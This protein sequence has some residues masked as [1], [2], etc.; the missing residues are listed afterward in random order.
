MI[1]ILTSA[2]AKAK[3]LNWPLMQNNI[4]R[5]DLNAAIEFL[6]QDDP[7]LT[8]SSQVQ[9]FE[10]E[11]SEWLGTKH[12]VFVNSGSSANLLTM[13]ALKEIYG[14]G[15]V[16][17]PTLAWVSDIAS[18]L[19]CGFKPVFV[20]ID[21]HTLGMDIDQVL[22]KISS[23]TRAVFLSH[24]LGYNALNQR[25]LNELKEQSIPLIED[26]CESCGAIYQG[27]KLGTFGLMSNFSFY[28]AHH[29]STIE[30]GMIST[31][32]PDFYEILRML[33]SHGM[34]R[35]TQSAE[36]QQLYCEQ[37]PDLS[38]DFIFAFPAYNVR[39]NEINAV[40]G[41]SQLR[42]LDD[43]NKIRT[44]NLK[45]FLENLNP[46]KYFTDFATEGSCNYA[47]ALVLR[48][49]DPALCEHVMQALRQHGIEFRR[50]GS[51]GGNQLR[52]PY[53]R[54][55]VG[56]A[57]F[58]NYPHVNHIHFYGFYIG[59]YPDLEKEKILLLCSI[60]NDLN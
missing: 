29:L 59:N 1:D 53:L 4:T 46:V 20:D 6:I 49:P 51:G 54:Q 16:I 40:I 23:K 36:L 35:E 10:Q 31:D 39:N 44:E 22:Q 32:N 15:E 47:L 34:V 58:E 25:L 56:K 2:P 24:I 28:Y 8:Q 3:K 27:R 26:V 38:P 17:V 7:I 30:G 43:N 9:A 45:L 41:R 60:L 11:W 37:H 52:Q 55:F 42:R 48:Q 19:Q 57:E 13:T 21:P 50:G 18:V 33:R 14:S 5:A 12:S